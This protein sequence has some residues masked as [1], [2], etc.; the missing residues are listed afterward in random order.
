MA[1]S[2]EIRIAD[3]PECEAFLD[4]AARVADEYREHGI[5]RVELGFDIE[6]MIAALNG[7]AGEGT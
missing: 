2:A 7:F 6:R 1:A 5:T 4:A 3:W